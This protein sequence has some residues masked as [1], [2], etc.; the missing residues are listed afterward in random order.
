M[1]VAT[2][3]AAAVL[4]V[5]Y[6]QSWKVNRERFVQAVAILQG[7]SPESLL[8]PPPPKKENDSE[9]PAYEQ[10]LAAQGL[11]ARDLEQREMTRADEYPAIPRGTRQ[12]C[13]RKETRAV[14][15]RRSAGEARRTERQA[16]RPRARKTSCRPCRRSNPSRPRNCSRRDWKKA[17]STSS[18]SCLTN[19]S[20]SKRAKIIAEFKTPDRDGADRRGPGPHPP[21]TTRRGHDR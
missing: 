11:K 3:I 2:V 17:T 21:G 9:Q 6:A 12:D 20:D 1:C 7:K 8:P 10:F 19:M 4:I 18:S 15:A 5:F 14:G 13:R 16:P